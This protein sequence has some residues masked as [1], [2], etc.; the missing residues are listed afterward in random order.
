MSRDL[1]DTPMKVL[2]IDGDAKA[3]KKLSRLLS[4]R[5]FDVTACATAEEAMIAYKT[6]F[7]PLLFIELAIGDGDGFAFTRWVRQQPEGNRQLILASAARNRS[8]DLQRILEA[9]ANDY[10]AKP[11][12][13][14]TLNVRLTIARQ[15]VKNIELRKSLESNLWQERERLRYLA[16]HDPLTK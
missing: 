4:D 9:G 3:R 7:F 15:R 12:R 11:Y 1:P 16:T 13:A 10:I 8:E 6:T 14:D 5:G 2:V